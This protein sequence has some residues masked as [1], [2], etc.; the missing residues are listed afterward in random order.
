MDVDVD[1]PAVL[2]SPRHHSASHSS[3]HHRSATPAD[4]PTLA[5]RNVHLPFESDDPTLADPLYNVFCVGGRVDRIEL[6]TPN[7][8]R[9]VSRSSGHNSPARSAE[10]FST[11]SASPRS[12]GLGVVTGLSPRGGSSHAELDAQGR[13]ILL[14][15]LVHA[16]I[17]LDKC[18][19]LD[20]CDELVTGNFSEAM[21]VTAKAKSG[22]ACNLEDLY[23][24]GR[25][26]ISQSIECGV[27]L[28]RAH[29]EVDETVHFACVEAGLRLRKLFRDI[30][31]IQIAAFAQEPFF[32]TAN[33]DRPGLNYVLLQNAIRRHGVEAVGSTPY[34]EPSISHAKRNIELIF[35][36]A[37][38]AG[39]HVDF[40]LDYNLEPTSEP[41]I[42][43]VIE[44]LRQ[45]IQSGRWRASCHVC[46]G[47]ATRLTLFSP[48]E[49]AALRAAL[50]D[51]RL[52]L[53]LV[54]L[55]PSDLYMMGRSLDF[56][57][58]GTLNVPRL[59]TEHGLRVAMSVNNVENAFT[60]QGPVDPLGLCP[61][62]VAVFQAGTKI[63]CRML[64]ESVTINSRLAIGGFHKGS[65][66][67]SLTPAP[68]MVADFVLLHENDTLHSAA[69]NPSFSR[70]T[71][72]HGVLVARRLQ[73]SWILPQKT[74]SPD[75]IPSE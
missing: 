72:R 2:P 1:M 27:T 75:P 48:E 66:A 65:P 63:D 32:A 21:R 46:V 44:Q 25:K 14:P 62:G 68:G 4:Y 20:Q 38:D 60:P 47:H 23:D 70:T 30:C 13:G 37:Y 59:A 69:L 43:H 54:G 52:P 29:V 51:E 35:D 49:W 56:A 34:V 8:S 42:W 33:D 67:M 40:H 18:F 74:P 73:Q 10:F 16:H 3:H 71:I 17:H 24:R 26:L 22:F 45:R 55:P 11:R 50:I 64:V 9:S 39:I 53:T 41:L 15:A 58:R 31:H 36:L 6:A 5:I 19:L 7:G 61:L 12:A 57:P 28:M